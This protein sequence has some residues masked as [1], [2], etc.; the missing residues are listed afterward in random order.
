MIKPLLQAIVLCSIASQIFSQTV[1]AQQT[2]TSTSLTDGCI[3]WDENHLYCMSCN[4][5][6]LYFRVKSSCVRCGDTHCQRIDDKGN[7]LSCEQGYY[8]RNGKICVVVTHVPGCV[9]YSTDAPTT[10]CMACSSSTLLVNNRCLKRIPN[11]DRYIPGTNL[12]ANCASGYTQSPN[13]S[14]CVTGGVGN[15]V[16]YDCQGLCVQCTEEFPRL[17]TKRNLCLIEIDYCRV[18]VGDQNTCKIC[19]D[20]YQLTSDS[21]RCLPEIV[22]CTEY[23]AS[24][25]GS[26]F[27][28]CAK[29]ADNFYVSVDKKQC[30]PIIKNCREIDYAN[31]ICL[32]C[33][34]F[35]GRVVVAEQEEA[36]K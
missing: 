25:K 15:C 20:G 33:G 4:L 13:W 34:Y 28:T 21:K 16:L 12:C 8:L 10:I 35:Q 17:S 26:K 23:L 19:Y 31:R 2:T 14:L 22:L 7:C 27:L 24:S 3:L 29:C 9:D 1:V 11:C 32:N 36:G 6:A 5:D 18:Y 30:L